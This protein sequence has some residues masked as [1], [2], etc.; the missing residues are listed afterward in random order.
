VFSAVS[1]TEEVLAFQLPTHTI[2][3]ADVNA[4]LA[5]KCL[6]TRYDPCFREVFEFEFCDISQLAARNLIKKMLAKWS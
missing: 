4:S 5:H 3:I 2:P 1:G 6:I